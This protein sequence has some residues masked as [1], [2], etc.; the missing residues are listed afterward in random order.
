MNFETKFCEQVIDYLK[1]EWFDNVLGSVRDHLK[2]IPQ[3]WYNLNEKNY[4]V[5]AMSKL[6]N[7]LNLIK[8]VMQVRNMKMHTMQFSCP[9]LC[10]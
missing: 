6:A 7:Y 4:D 3:S 2:K 10:I 8:L 1:S 5:F 9:F